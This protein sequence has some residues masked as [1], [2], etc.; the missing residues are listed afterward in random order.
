MKTKYTIFKLLF[1]T[2]LAL[3]V[4]SVYAVDLEVSGIDNPAAANGVYVYQGQIFG[5]DYWKHESQ[6]YYIY[7]DDYAGRYWNIDADTDDNNDVY[8][9]SSNPSSVSSPVDVPSWDALLGSGAPIVVE[10]NTAS[11]PSATTNAASSVLVSGATLNATVNDNGTSTSVTFE[12]GTTAGYGSSV[13]AVQSPLSP[14]SGNTSVSAPVSGLIAGTTYHYR[15]AAENTEGITYGTDQTFT[16][17]SPE[18]NLQGN[19]TSIADGDAT[20]T[21]TDHTDFGSVPAA[22]GSITRTFTIQNTGSA[23]L[24]L[25]DASP[26][27]TIN[28][29]HAGD[30]SVSSSPSSSISPGSSTTFQI[31]FDPSAIGTRSATLSIANNDSDENPYNFSVRGT[32]ANSAPTDIS[33]SFS[34]IDENASDGS[35][36]GA[37]TTTDAD[38]GDGHTYALVSGSGDADNSSF[39]VTGSNLLINS[40]PD[41]EI[42]NSYSVRVQSDDGTD[43]YAESFTITINDLND[44]TPVITTS[45]SFSIDEDA[46]NNTTVGSVAAT[47]GDAGTTL[48][49]WTI[50]GGNG[51][52][53]FT[54]NS[55]SGEITVADNTNMDYETTPSYSISITV[56]DGANT[57][58][59]ATVTV[60]IND[61]SGDEPAVSTQAVTDISPTST[62]GNGNIT[63]LGDPNLTAYGVCWNTSGS[64]TT[65]DNYTD[66]GISSSTGAFTSSITSLTPNTTY[67]VR[68]YATNTAG[69]VYGNEVSF[70]TPMATSIKTISDAELKVY[71]NPTSGILYVADSL[72]NTKFEVFNIAG[73]RVKSGN[74]N[75]N[76]INL[77]D[78][79]TGIYL[80]I[81]NNSK[82]RVIKK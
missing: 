7:N 30:F 32:G 12:Y 16:T 50:T 18:I 74:I 46:A 35:T 39:T 78:L 53:I 8:F 13:T 27:V 65:A 17:L 48:S 22:S 23:T 36:I 69:T 5:Y 34:T 4:T 45:Q 52:G 59:S 1:V 3:C 67:Y 37:L 41:Y 62:T 81:I 38:T 73:E 33:L 66:E 6:E 56:S 75:D 63:N 44:N 47:D 71:P 54:L 64:P 61:I 42:Q 70:T 9:Y 57:S 82:Y 58:S 76:I 43:T 79:K 24:N 19:A 21:T 29:T 40:S 26:Y 28:G 51:D 77:A 11:V 2:L 31:S 20:P 55:S 60:N 68:A 25:T 14:G 80:I 15:V 49:S 10:Y 72:K